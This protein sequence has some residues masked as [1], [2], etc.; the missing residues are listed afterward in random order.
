MTSIWELK[1]TCITPMFVHSRKG[2][3]HAKKATACS[4]TLSITELGDTRGAT[5]CQFPAIWCCKQQCLKQFGYAHAAAAFQFRF[6]EAI[7]ETEFIVAQFHI[8]RIFPDPKADIWLLQEVYFN[9]AITMNPPKLQ[10][11]VVFFYCQRQITMYQPSPWQ[12]QLMACIQRNLSPQD[13]Y[14]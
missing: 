14:W 2:I 10:N 13:C 11:L 12:Q 3:C 6:N 5:T 8:T 9:F 7:G 4:S 1:T